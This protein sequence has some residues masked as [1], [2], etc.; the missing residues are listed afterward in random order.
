MD[1]VK[2]EAEP[3]QNLREYLWSERAGWFW[4]TV[5]FAVA[6][7][8]TVIAVPEDSY[9]TL[10]YLRY[11]LSLV[12]VLFLPGYTLTKAVFSTRVLV[13]RSSESSDVIERVA[14][15][16]GM[17]VA[18]AAIVGLLL[19]YTPWGIRPAPITLTLLALTVTFALTALLRDYESE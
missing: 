6:T 10:V 9:P 2:K 13:K 3:P 18:L 8:M 5:L 4:V 7:T 14:L 16:F 17:S 19:N 15:S 11:V 12:F 1:N